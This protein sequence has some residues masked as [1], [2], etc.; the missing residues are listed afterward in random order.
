ML[1]TLYDNSIKLLSWY[2]GGLDELINIL[3]VCIILNSL[4]SLLLS[5]I[6]KN[7]KQ[8][9]SKKRICKKISIFIV[10]GL[11]HIIDVY[12]VDFINGFRTTTILFY[13]IYEV[14]TI[15]IKI[16]EVGLPIP[17]PIINFL[18]KIKHKDTN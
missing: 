10:I 18:D 7:I 3:I 6:N 9:I 14:V 11:S 2:L 17:K 1:Q 16:T 15:L 13:I 8:Y 12:L 4:M 5:F